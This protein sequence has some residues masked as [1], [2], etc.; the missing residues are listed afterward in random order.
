MQPNRYG[1]ACSTCST[2]VAPQQGVCRNEHGQWVVYCTAHGT[3][4]TPTMAPAAVD[5]DEP[6][7]IEVRVTG[8]LAQCQV[9]KEALQ[10]AAGVTVASVS[11][12]TRGGTPTTTA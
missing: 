6:P 2:Y 8:S 9:I 11:A 4:R 3:T 1:G 5:T 12:P 7:R 10:M